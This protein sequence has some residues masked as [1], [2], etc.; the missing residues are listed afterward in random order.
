MTIG[1]LLMTYG[2]PDGDADLPRYLAAVRGGRPADADLVAEMRR[3]YE[4]IGGSP[5][6]RLTTAQAAA[7]EEFIGVPCAAAMR[8]SEPSIA[9]AARD[10]VARGARHVVGIVLSPQWSSLLMGGYVRTLAAAAT[11]LGVSWSA[12]E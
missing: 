12:P 9:A 11:E 8:F 1:V 4:R 6:I 5:L 7:L 10:L 2:A 3:R